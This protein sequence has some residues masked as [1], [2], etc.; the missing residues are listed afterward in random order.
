[1][2]ANVNRLRRQRK[3][4]RGPNTYIFKPPSRIS[5]FTVSYFESLLRE[6]FGPERNDESILGYNIRIFVT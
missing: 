3:Q 1:V 6:K 5:N 2:F 4:F